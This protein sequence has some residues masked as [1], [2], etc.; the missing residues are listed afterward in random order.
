MAYR[1]FRIVIRPAG[2]IGTPWQSDTLFGHLAWLV[3]MR[4]GGDGVRAFL[5]PF[6]DGE[7]PFVLSDGFPG[8]LLPA[9]LLDAGSLHGSFLSAED[10]A[11]AK[12]MKNARFLTPEGFQD[13]R[14]SGAVRS[15]L[16]SEPY[17]TAET[18]HASLD[19]RT[20][21]TGGEGQLFATVETFLKDSGPVSVY[22]RCMESAADNFQD[23]F[24]Q[25]SLVGYGR[26]KSSGI[27]AFQVE[28]WEV[29]DG[30]GS[31]EGANGF[32]SLSSFVPA[33]HDPV[34]GGWRL[35]VKRGFLG[36]QVGSGNPFKRPMLQFEP[37]AVFRT[38]GAPRPWYGRVVTGIAPGK[39]E[40]VQNCH[41]I[42][43]PCRFPEG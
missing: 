37:G 40:A 24:Q 1:D 17:L 39:P 33:E 29:F 26:D 16:R 7:P 8:D 28:A 6:L 19:R 13:A 2:P 12:Q 38:L 31:F 3:A 41:T 5:E 14:K 10:Y 35:R 22:A 42:A 43:V 27:G 11:R 15:G 32:I 21:A 25:L 4:E 18:L 20:N 34:E 9:P 36:E 30:F 23:R